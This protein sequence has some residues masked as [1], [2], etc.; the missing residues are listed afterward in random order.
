MPMNNPFYFHFFNN[1]HL[2]NVSNKVFYVFYNFK[3]YTAK[4]LLSINHL[5]KRIEFVLAT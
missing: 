2:E 3:T 5:N 1:E 4:F